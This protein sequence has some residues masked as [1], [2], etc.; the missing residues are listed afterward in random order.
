MAWIIAVPSVAAAA[1]TAAASVKAF[2]QSRVDDRVEF[3]T[4]P[5]QVMFMSWGRHS[6]WHWMHSEFS[7]NSLGSLVEEH[8]ELSM[9]Y[10]EWL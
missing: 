9:P 8:S 4:R 3:L 5:V 2:P 10:P 6:G 7:T 1:A